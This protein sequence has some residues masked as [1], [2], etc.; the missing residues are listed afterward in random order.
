MDLDVRRENSRV[1]TT[2]YARVSGIEVVRYSGPGNETELTETDRYYRVR[3]QQYLAI[4]AVVLPLGPSAELAVG[5]SAEYVKTWEGDGRIVD[6]TRPYGAGAWGQVA[7]RA[8]LVWDSR[9]HARYPTRGV[10]GRVDG[11]AIP[12]VWDVDSA[13]G[14]V[15]GSLAA[16][17]SARGVPGRPTLALRAGGRKVWGPYPFFAS[18]FI[19]DAASVRLGR[20]HRYAGDAAAYGNAE[21]RLRLTR[22]FVLLPGE[23]GV[24][25][26][27]D[28]GRV[29][30]EGETSNRWHTAFGGGIWM[31]LLQHTTVLSA[32]VARSSERTGFYVGT[33]MA[34]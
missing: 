19:G 21:L 18:A 30:L 34:F 13:Y 6:V 3:Q 14:F 32:S 31:S 1:R 10:F 12:A 27:A 22:F 28:A 25:G 33:G 20:Q 8:R 24:F 16:Y 23:F 17:A 15:D 26:L 2:L 29:F 4:P 11:A 7:G 5:P 9:D